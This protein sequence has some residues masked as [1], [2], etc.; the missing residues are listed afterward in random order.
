MG[1]GAWVRSQEGLEKEVLRVFDTRAEAE[2][3]EEQLIRALGDNPNCRNIHHIIPKNLDGLC[4]KVNPE[5]RKRFRT[6]ALAAGLKLN[7]LLTESLGAWERANGLAPDKQSP[8]LQIKQA[9]LA[10][11]RLSKTA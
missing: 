6:R 5:F 1:S 7:E 8:V 2:R 9:M 4:F 11:R 10:L 3:L